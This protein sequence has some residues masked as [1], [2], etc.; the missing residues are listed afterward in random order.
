MTHG[1]PRESEVTEDHRGGN[2]AVTLPG[3]LNSCGETGPG[4]VV[5]LQDLERRR[6]H[7]LASPRRGLI[8]LTTSAGIVAREEPR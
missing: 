5:Q 1:H 6:S 8:V 4:C 2:T 3:R 7:P